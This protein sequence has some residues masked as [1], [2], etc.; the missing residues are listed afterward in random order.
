MTKYSEDFKKQVKAFHQKGMLLKRYKHD[1]IHTTE[2][3][4]KKFGL[5]VDQTKNILY[6]KKPNN[7]PRQQSQWHKPSWTLPKH[8]PKKKRLSEN[9]AKGQFVDDPRAEEYDK[10]GR[11]SFNNTIAVLTRNVL[12][13]ISDYDGQKKYPHT[14]SGNKKRLVPDNKLVRNRPVNRIDRLMYFQMVGSDK[15][16]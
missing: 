9:W 11:I 3:V 8:V 4:A 10:Y 14:S 13:E 1:K 15:N 12:D 6:Q 5:T 7:A 2:D 16:G